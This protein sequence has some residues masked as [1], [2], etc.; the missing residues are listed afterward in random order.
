MNYAAGHLNLLQGDPGGLF[1]TSDTDRRPYTHVAF[2]SIVN[3]L[4]ILKYC[5]N[6]FRKFKAI[7]LSSFTFYLSLYPKFS[8]SLPMRQIQMIFS[9]QILE[10]IYIVFIEPNNNIHF[11]NKINRIHF[12][13]FLNRNLELE[14][15]SIFQKLYIIFYY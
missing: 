7:Y 8:L 13:I 2:T 5:L 14:R 4:F 6:T 11:V 3:L 1:S 12:R 15:T 10:N 9:S